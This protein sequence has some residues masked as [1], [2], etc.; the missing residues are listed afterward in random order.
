[1]N[2]KL[3]AVA[4]AAASALLAGTAMAADKGGAP[5]SVP[6]V[7]AGPVETAPYRSFTGC[8][9]GGGVGYSVSSTEGDFLY[10]GVALGGLDGFGA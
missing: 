9:G 4:A 10:K 2:V 8:Y 6:S 1:M 7:A 3:S 5:V